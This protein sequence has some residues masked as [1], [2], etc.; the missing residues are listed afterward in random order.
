MWHKKSALWKLALGKHQT[1][2]VAVWVCFCLPTTYRVCNIV[3]VLSY[4][5]IVLWPWNFPSTL[6]RKRKRLPI[7]FKCLACLI[8]LLTWV[9]I[10]PNYHNCVL[11]IKCHIASLGATTDFG[12]VK[13]R[14]RL[15]FLRTVGNH[16]QPCLTPTEST[17]HPSEQLPPPLSFQQNRSIN[18]VHLTRIHSK[19]VVF[20]LLKKYHINTNYIFSLKNYFS[21]QKKIQLIMNRVMLSSGREICNFS[22]GLKRV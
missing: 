10:F 15:C 16:N 19:G 13:M 14:Q 8:K 7:P 21:F 6:Q 3:T 9:T 17:S 5:C 22:P 11:W 12:F 18:A 2:P 1:H 4:L 20:V